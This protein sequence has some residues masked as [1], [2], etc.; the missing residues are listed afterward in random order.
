MKTTSI[1]TARQSSRLARL[2]HIVTGAWA[3]V[4][5]MATAANLGLVQMMEFQ[6]HSLF[7]E[8]R[9]P[10]APPENIV[11]LA[12]DELSLSQEQYYRTDPQRYAY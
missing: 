12:I 2:S 5:G 10:V 7:F 11:I 9:G 6:V 1:V 4:A 8:L 3:L